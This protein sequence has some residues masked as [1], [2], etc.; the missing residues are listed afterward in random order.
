MNAKVVSLLLMLLVSLRCNGQYNY[1]ERTR[2][3]KQ[4]DAAMRKLLNATAVLWLRRVSDAPSF[5][6][7]TKCWYSKKVE[8]NGLA[9]RHQFKHL[10]V[11][12]DTY[13][14]KKGTAYQ[15]VSIAWD[16]YYYVGPRNGSTSL[17][18]HAFDTTTGRMILSK[19]YTV[20]I[21]RETCFVLAFPE[22]N[23]AYSS[24]SLW[25]TANGTRVDR[26]CFFAYKLTCDG[27]D[28]RVYSKHCRTHPK[29][30]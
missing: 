10:Q 24:C 19:T 28:I 4:N 13:P 29:P 2:K 16:A 8:Y 9:F 3:D 27:A 25:S 26:L 30:R 17:V 22:A 15:L 18:V 14:P 6:L 7:G 23:G 11:V 12:L 21:A 20:I 1:D 5:L